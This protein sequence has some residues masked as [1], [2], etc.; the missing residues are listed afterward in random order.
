MSPFKF[1][2][3]SAR[4]RLKTRK[5]LGLRISFTLR[6]ARMLIELRKNPKRPGRDD[7]PPKI[8]FESEKR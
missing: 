5:L 2:L 4:A 6:K 1:K 3:R 7:K 8:N